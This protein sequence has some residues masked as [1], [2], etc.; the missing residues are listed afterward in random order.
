MKQLPFATV[1]NNTLL[2]QFLEQPQDLFPSDV[3]APS[4]KDPVVVTGQQV[5]LFGGPLYTLLKIRTA[6]QTALDTSRMLDR[7]VKAVFWLEDNDHDATEASTTW[8]P[9]AGHELSKHI[10]VPTGNKTSV[11]ALTFTNEQSSMVTTL[12]SSL[13]G[14]YADE[15]RSRLKNVYSPERKWTDVCIDVLKP[16]LD[17]WN[18][19]VIRA[20]NVIAQGAHRDL[21]KHDI[22]STALIDA[23][24]DTSTHL[25]SLGHTLQATPGSTLFFLNVDGERQRLH[26]EAADFRTTDGSTWSADELLEILEQQPERFTPTVLGR[27][28]VQ[29]HYLNTI[30]NVLGVAELS[31]HAQL[32]K[33]YTTLGIQQPLPVLRHHALIL[34]ARTERLIEKL[35]MEPEAF[36]QSLEILEATAVSADVDEI[37]SKLSTQEQTAAMMSPFIQTVTALDATLVKS[38]ESAAASVEATMDGIRGKIR[39]AIKRKNTERLD[40]IRTAWWNIYPG[41]THAERI[42]PLALYEARLGFSGL[43]IIVENV[44]SQSNNLFTIISSQDTTTQQ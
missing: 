23:I 4:G 12:L 24:K 10:L 7:P 35:S 15:V 27:P 25:E 17:A 20:S 37:L 13:D 16:Y 39:T 18:V 5:G 21:V 22:E 11:S 41:F 28:L 42:I 44:C 9:E 3:V 34:D 32:K 26:R 29:D 43:R 1:Y 8:L 40:R 36:F 19:E 6:A 31:Y 30:H 38:V 14:R 2:A 33:A